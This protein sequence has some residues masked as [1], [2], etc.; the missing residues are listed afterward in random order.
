[1]PHK[2][3][4]KLGLIANIRSQI[5][6]SV[7]CI[8]EPGN[9]LFLIPKPI[10]PFGVREDL[11]NQP[12]HGPAGALPG[13]LVQRHSLVLHNVNR[14]HRHGIYRFGP[15]IANLDLFWFVH[16]QPAPETHSV[17]KMFAIYRKISRLGRTA[18]GESVFR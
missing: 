17:N 14:A 6:P 8:V 13:A 9:K 7:I 3:S 12:T 5:L 15:L 18:A 1:M 4:L 10:Y 2:K 11:Q 16:T